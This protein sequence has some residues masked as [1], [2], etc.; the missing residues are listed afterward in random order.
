MSNVYFLKVFF[1][2]KP[3]TSINFVNFNQVLNLTTSYVF[4]CVLT[5]AYIDALIIQ[6]CGRKD[7]NMV[8]G[9][10][11]GIGLRWKTYVVRE[12]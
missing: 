9:L 7:E 12:K 11:S 1:I 8:C 4:N 3:Y 5:Y 2:T 10:E 6:A